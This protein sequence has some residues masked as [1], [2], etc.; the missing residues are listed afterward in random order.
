MKDKL[1]T[2]DGPSASGKSTVSRLLAEKLGW[3]WVSTGAFYRGLA[4]VAK[5]QKVAVDDE[6]TLTQLVSDPC[7][8][9]QL[10]A[11]KTMVLYNHKDITAEISGEEVGAFASKISQLPG[12]RQALLDRQ[13]A[14][15]SSGGPGLIAEGRD[16]GTV[17][18]PEAPLKVYLT[19]DPSRRAQRR[20]QD[21]EESVEKTLE[22]QK[23][24]DQ[25]DSER[26]QAPLKAAQ[27]AIIIDSSDMSLNQV[28]DQ[29]FGLY[30][31]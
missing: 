18:F 28:V 2:I 13:R 17:V 5:D 15:F 4:F 30:Q 7:W 1:I 3:S 29:I 12:V 8:K 9:I 24:R 14:C 19:A 27:G 10:T 23:K 6:T 31:A 21:D 26:K 25:Q 11:V 22:M 16:C 20:S